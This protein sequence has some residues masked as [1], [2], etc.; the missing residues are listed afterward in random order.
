VRVF[1]T[2][3]TGYLGLRLAAGLRRAGHEVTALVRNRGR[4]AALEAIGARLVEGDVTA[5][6]DA[7][8]DYRS[9]DAC[10]HGAAVVKVRGAGPG[11]FDLT[12]VAG[13]AAVA[14]RFL[15]AGIKRFL[16]TS[17]FMALGPSPDG[18]PLDETA[19]HDPLHVHNDYERTKYLGL[20][21]FESWASRGL[22]GI[23][24]VPCVV[25][26]PGALTH[27]NLVSKVVADIIKRRFPGVLGDG[28]TVWTYSFVEDVVEGHL[29][30]LEKGQPGERYILGGESVTMERFVAMVAEL[31]GVEAPRRHIPFW[32]AKAGALAEETLATVRHR[33]PELSR[34]VV[35][36]YR[37]HWTY[38]SAKAQRDLG[39]RIT[40]LAS[41]L[42]QTVAWARTQIE[43]GKL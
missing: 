25:Y 22:P 2:G 17:S 7:V 35:E 42:A 39:Y 29:A 26:G 18:S 1:L 13:V 3:G 38:S 37:H 4:A 12:N 43:Q 40:P 23:T 10:I 30:A 36:I 14:E 24:L 5:L 27:G 19:S 8:I 41:G 32:V 21:E 34:Q 28:R 31:A 33:E 11:E 6:G 20:L 16:Y 9:F 15:D